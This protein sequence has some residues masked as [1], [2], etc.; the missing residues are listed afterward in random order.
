MLWAL[1]AAAADVLDK[2]MMLATMLD[3]I[4]KFTDENKKA[5]E[6]GFSMVAT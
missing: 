6:I 3:I 1:S 2:Q 5:L 4:P